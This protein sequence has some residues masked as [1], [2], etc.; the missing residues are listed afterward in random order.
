MWYF[1][2]TTL[3]TVGYG[4]FAP[5]AIE[6]KL[7]I[8]FVL[9]FAVNIFSFIMGKFIDILVN[10]KSIYTFE[11][12]NN[13]YKWTALLAKFNDSN[14]LSPRIINAIEDYFIFYWTNNRLSVFNSEESMRFLNELPE[15]TQ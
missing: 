3:S 12:H 1:G 10:Y 7:I 4:D 2:I 8:F 6:E 15:S 13:L 11:D 14:P 5:K 9:F